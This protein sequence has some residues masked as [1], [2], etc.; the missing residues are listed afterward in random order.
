[1][2]EG[3]RIAVESGDLDGVIVIGGS[4]DDPDRQR[5]RSS[6]P[7]ELAKSYLF[8]EKLPRQL[9]VNGLF[10]YLV[11]N[12]TATIFV[13]SSRYDLVPYTVLEA[14]RSGLCTIVPSGGLVG[15]SEYLPTEYQFRPTPSGLAS[16]IS[17][18]TS[19]DDLSLNFRPVA[20]SIHRDTGDDAFMKAFFAH[21][22]SA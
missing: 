22:L 9:L 4:T 16:R 10:P 15:A 5:L 2:I 14:A 7:A 13:C 12:T 20:E 11:S 17:A 1:M 8:L 21:C 3:T 19:D 6:L 18:L